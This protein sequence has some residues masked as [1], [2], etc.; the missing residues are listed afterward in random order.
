MKILT[1]YENTEG[2]LFRDQDECLATELQAVRAST[3]E[4]VKTIL[5][6]SGWDVLACADAIREALAT[7]A[8]ELAEVQAQIDVRALEKIAEPVSG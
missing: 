7:G 1:V 8:R 5:T 2:Q 3:S 6:D 4:K